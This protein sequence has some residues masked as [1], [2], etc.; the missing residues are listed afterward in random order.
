LIEHFE[1]AVAH[2]E[3]PVIAGSSRKRLVVN[4]A[5][6]V[7]D[8]AR[9][10]SRGDNRFF[11]VRDGLLEVLDQPVLSTARSPILFQGSSSYGDSTEP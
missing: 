4:C 1:Q 2:H 8:D 9:A 6:A 3:K 7:N 10:C 5:A 11:M